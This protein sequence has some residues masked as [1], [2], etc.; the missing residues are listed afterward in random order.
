MIENT[1]NE[2]QI[3]LKKAIWIITLV[4]T[5]TII[6]IYGYYKT[7]YCKDGDDFANAQKGELWGIVSDF[8]LMKRPNDI[9]SPNFHDDFLIA[10]VD[11]VSQIAIIETKQGWAKIAVLKNLNVIAMGW[12]DTKSIKCARNLTKWM[13]QSFMKTDTTLVR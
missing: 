2:K 1:E 12:V 8:D 6:F 5:I 11:S 3:S 9:S 4:I 10:R 13:Q 7:N